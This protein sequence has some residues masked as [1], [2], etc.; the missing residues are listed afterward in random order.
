MV[1][2]ANPTTKKLTFIEDQFYEPMM[3][4]SNLQNLIG[5]TDKEY[6]MLIDCIAYTNEGVVEDTRWSTGSTLERDIASRLSVSKS[7]DI[8]KDSQMND[9]IDNRPVHIYF[10]K[11]EKYSTVATPELARQIIYCSSWNEL[12]EHFKLKPVSICVNSSHTEKSSLIE[13]INM[14]DT[15]AKLVGMANKLTVTLGLNKD[16]EHAL[17]KEAQKLHITGIIP[18]RDDFGQDEC[19]KGINA[20]WN[21][22]PYWPKHIIEQ[23]PGAKKLN[24]VKPGEIKLT[25]RQEQILHLIRERGLSNKVIAKTLN[26]TESTV[27]LHVGLVLKKF[28]VKNRTQ[29]AVYSKK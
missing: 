14:I 8:K 12:V 29:L 26:I 2:T 25:P 27:K 6:Q 23:L 4:N 17:V 5:A 18:S 24:R 10:G 20:Q 1:V 11:Y 3:E 15:F 21:N 28:G 22:I 9:V 16:T 19:L 7:I 13:I